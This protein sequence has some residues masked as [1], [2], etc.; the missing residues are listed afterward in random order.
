MIDCQPNT[1]EYKDLDVNDKT[2]RKIFFSLERQM[3]DRL[4]SN[5]VHRIA[6]IRQ[7]QIQVVSGIKYRAAFNFGETNCQKTNVKDIKSCDFNGKYLS[8]FAEIW[9]Q[10]WL[11]KTVLLHFTCL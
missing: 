8:C 10:S 4:D 7:A 6:K 9:S 3:D 2:F 11:N 5:I 1:G